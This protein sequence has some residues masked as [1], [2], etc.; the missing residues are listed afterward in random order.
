MGTIVPEAI[1]GNERF[2]FAGRNSSGRGIYLSDP[3]GN[4]IAPASAQPGRIARLNEDFA[5][6]AADE[7][8]C[9]VCGGFFGSGP[10]VLIEP[11]GTE[12]AMH[13]RCALYAVVAC[14]HIRNGARV[15]VSAHLSIDEEDTGEPYFMAAG[16]SVEF[17]PDAHGV[18]I[19]YAR[20]Y[21]GHIA[22]PEHVCELVQRALALEV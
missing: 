10:Y 19:E 14:P 1:L 12:P 6:L 3:R 8:L 22:K 2:R 9:S 13:V 21:S 17:G 5:A 20:I 4:L 7:M 15:I 11:A 16:E 18:F